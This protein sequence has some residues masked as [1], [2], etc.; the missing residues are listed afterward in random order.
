L[1]WTL[2]LDRSFGQSNWS[3][4]WSVAIATVNRTVVWTAARELRPRMRRSAGGPDD[5]LSDG[6]SKRSLGSSPLAGSLFR[7]SSKGGPLSAAVS[8]NCGPSSKDG[9]FGTGFEAQARSRE[10]APSRPT[11]ARKPLR[12]AAPNA[13]P[14]GRAKRKDPAGFKTV[15]VR[16]R[17]SLGQSL[18]W[19]RCDGPSAQSQCDGRAATAP[20]RRPRCAV[21]LRRSRCDGPSATA[22]LRLPRYEGFSATVPLRRSRCDG[23][24]ATIPLKVTFGPDSRVPVA[25]VSAA[26][27]PL[28][29]SVSNS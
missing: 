2:P 25:G 10:G 7:P 27:E 29:F 14:P 26:V 11:L 9:P 21:A 23:P 24:A 20:L 13:T 19:S 22:P 5:G 3:V 15:S 28:W 18:G 12:T 17:R 16:M 4:P 1:N 6:S 8:E